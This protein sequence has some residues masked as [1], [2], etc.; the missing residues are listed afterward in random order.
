MANVLWSPQCDTVDARDPLQAH[1]KER[2]PSLPLGS[3]LN[4][5]ERDSG[6][7]IMVMVMVVIMIVVVVMIVTVMIMLRLGV[8]GMNFFDGCHLCGDEGSVSRLIQ[9]KWQEVAPRLAVTLAAQ[10][11]ISKVRLT[12]VGCREPVELVGDGEIAVRTGSWETRP[13]CRR[14]AASRVQYLLRLWRLCSAHVKMY[15]QERFIAFK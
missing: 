12:F 14:L 13:P 4:L 2:L 11:R 8:V 15:V 10:P 3:R 5:V 9:F 7:V 6:N 1:A